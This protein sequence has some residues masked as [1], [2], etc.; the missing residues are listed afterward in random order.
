VTL[1]GVMATVSCVLLVFALFDAMA[2]IGSTETQESVRDFLATGPGGSLGLNVDGVTDIL[3]GVVLFSGALAAA[4]VILAVYCLRRHRG[5]RIGLSV[6]AVLMLFTTTFVAGLLPF[7]VALAASMLWRREARDWFDG[8]EPGQVRRPAARRTTD[9]GGQPATMA[10]WAPPQPSQ[11]PAQPPNQPPDQQPSQQPSQPAGSA[12]GAWPA[13]YPAWGSG[14]DGYGTQQSRRRP[15]SVTAAVW[16]TWVSCALTVLLLALVVLVLLVQR[17]QLVTELRKNP[18]VASAGYTADQL[19]ASLWVVAAVGIFWSLAAMALGVLAFQ[20]MRAGQVGLL[21]SAVM[22][23]VFGI[24]TVVVPVVA[25]TTVVLLLVGSSNQWFAPA[26]EG[27]PP[28]QPPGGQPPAG[29]PPAG[30]PP[31]GQPPGG[32]PPAGQP[33]G[34]PPVW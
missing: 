17:D 9:A 24:A 19:V 31:G 34:N 33:P 11:A 16:I 1:A 30:Q 32:Q 5:A 18:T 12:P 8:R 28:Q 2:A 29:Q 6:V 7:V 20:G 14:A 10:A 4:G 22:A 13:G 21:L 3:R 15:G 27:G 26:G 23:G 25:A